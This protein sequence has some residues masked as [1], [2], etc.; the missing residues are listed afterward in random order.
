[1][2]NMNNELN[3]FYDEK[4]T[5]LINEHL[6]F[7]SEY[8]TILWNKIKSSNIPHSKDR[9]NIFRDDP[10]R[11]QIEKQIS[12]IQELSFPIRMEIIDFNK[13]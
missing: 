12:K 5:S 10:V 13:E 1:M 7:L 3:V 9:V 11:C 8:E 6:K 4:T 2:F